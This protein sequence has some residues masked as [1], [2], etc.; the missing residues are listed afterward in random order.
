MAYLAAIASLVGTAT[1][2]IGN[3]QQ[4]A[5]AEQNAQTMAAQL[6]Q[7]ANATRASAQRESI[8]QQRQTQFMTSRAQA[9]AAA[10]GGGASDPT[11][12]NNIANIEGEGE[13]RRLTALYNG[14]S[15]ATGQENQAR[16]VER[17]GQASAQAATVANTSTI[18]N[19]ASSYYQKYGAPFRRTSSNVSDP[20]MA[21]Y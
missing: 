16:V 3:N 7:N 17:G 13:Y 19:S 12:V 6:R 9:V 5:A 20:G 14:E 2:V 1:T 15:Q 10:S 4:G 18:L 8:N 11:V 21:S